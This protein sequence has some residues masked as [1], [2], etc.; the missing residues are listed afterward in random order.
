METYTHLLWYLAYPAALTP[1]FL[2]IRWGIKHVKK[3]N[4]FYKDNPD[5]IPSKEDQ[6]QCCLLVLLFIIILASLAK[7]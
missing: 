1:H 4:K 7:K 5:K 3:T 6:Q 2:L